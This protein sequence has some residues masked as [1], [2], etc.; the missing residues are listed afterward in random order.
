M[1]QGEAARPYPALWA[2]RRELSEPPMCADMGGFNE[3]GIS[4]I[5]AT[6]DD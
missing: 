5:A 1:S 2:A 3:W 4:P 6:A